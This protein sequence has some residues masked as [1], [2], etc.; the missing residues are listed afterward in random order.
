MFEKKTCERCGKQYSMRTISENKGRHLCRDCVKSCSICGANLPMS[1]WLGQTYTVNPLAHSFE[2]Q[3]KPW[4]GSGMCMACF[5]KKIE[6]EEQEQELIR[7]AKL[8]HAKEILETPT[9]W[10]CIYCKTINRGN[11]CANCGSPRKK[12]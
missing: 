6:Q 8:A 4:I 7:K 3:E 5:N 9:V 12:A 11:F 2:R 10:E 1:N